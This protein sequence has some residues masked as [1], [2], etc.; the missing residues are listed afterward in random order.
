MDEHT[1]RIK[2]IGKVLIRRR[3]LMDTTHHR[4]R[5]GWAE[6]VR[7]T[8]PIGDP[9]DTVRDL[10]TGA[11]DTYDPTTLAL[12]EQAYELQSGSLGEALQGGYL[13]AADGEHLYPPPEHPDYEQ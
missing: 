7:S 3:I 6:T 5:D 8:T 2:N 9:Y 11:R 1:Q 12:L 10:E 4:T 13:V